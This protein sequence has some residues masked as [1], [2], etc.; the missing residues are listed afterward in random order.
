MRL[1]ALEHPIPTWRE[2][3]KNTKDAVLTM[4]DEMKSN[5]NTPHKK[6]QLKKKPI[7]KRKKKK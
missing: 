4:A 6:K 7:Q 1:N 2:M 5:K 3:F